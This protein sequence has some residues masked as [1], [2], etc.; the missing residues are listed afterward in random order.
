MAAKI[1]ITGGSGLVGRAISELLIN[2]GHT[3]VW[4]SRE[5]G[6]SKGIKKFKW[7]LAAKYIDEKA[8][9]GVET[10]IHLAG[11]GITG[12]RW[13][14]RYK[15]EIIDSRVKSSELLYSYISK[16]THPVKTLVGTSAIGYY[17][18]IQ[19]DQVF[20]E[21]DAP[22]HDFMAECCV[23]WEKSY[24]PFINAGIRVPIIRTGV[25]LSEKGGAYK[26]LAIPAK[27]GFGA[28]MGSGEQYFPW[29]HINDLAGIYLKAIVDEQMTG[30]YNAVGPE[31]VTNKGF[32]RQLSKSLHRPFFMPNIPAAL[33]KIAVGESAIA[34]TEGLQISAQKI[35]AAGFKFEFDTLGAALHDLVE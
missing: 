24:G 27:L 17:G 2:K 8:F 31:L 29:I 4:L 15:K 28:A 33:L 13:T 23:L 16:N 10:I 12:K 1:L 25:V 5:A 18:A 22:G 35:K 21:D 19:S 34:I 26:T 30:P 32:S 9:E 14:E 3:P 11:S 6:E 20:T 7:D